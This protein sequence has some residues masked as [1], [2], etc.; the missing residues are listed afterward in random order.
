[1][2]QLLTSVLSTEHRSVKPPASFKKSIPT[3]QPDT[4]APNGGALHVP[5]PNPDHGACGGPTPVDVNVLDQRPHDGGRG[6]GVESDPRLR[7]SG[8]YHHVPE[9]DNGDPA[10]GF[11]MLKGR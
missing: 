4:T 2:L 3:E 6:R 8:D 5:E 9:A 1:M 7:A 10:R 11:V